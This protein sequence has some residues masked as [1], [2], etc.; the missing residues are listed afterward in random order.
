MTS[1]FHFTEVIINGF[2][3]PSTSLLWTLF[4]VFTSLPISR[5]TE[6]F[7]HISKCC[8]CPELGQAVL[9]QQQ[10]KTYC[11]DYPHWRSTQDWGTDAIS[12][13]GS[14][15]S[16]PTHL[17]AWEQGRGWVDAWMT[18]VLDWWVCPWEREHGSC[19]LAQRSGE[20]QKMLW[21][22]IR[23]RTQ[24]RYGKR[25]TGKRLAGIGEICQAQ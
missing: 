25:H 5:C 8:L 23:V 22:K 20:H 18:R 3:S 11:C 13:H 17:L 2:T 15:W 6:F 12:T 7:T 9:L 19:S 21:A 14:A 1:I 16:S 10:F 24:H 4:I